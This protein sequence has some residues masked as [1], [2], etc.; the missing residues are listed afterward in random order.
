MEWLNVGSAARAYWQVLGASLPEEYRFAKRS[1][2]P[3][4]DDFN[5]ALN[6]LYGMLYSVVEGALFAAGLDPHL[7]ILHTD[8]YNKPVLVFDLIEAF[9]PWVDRLLVEECL[10]SNLEAQFF[11]KN[12]FGL[13]LN[14]KGKAYIIPLFNDYLRTQRRYFQRDSTVK[15]H[16]Y[17]LAARLANRIRTF[18][19]EVDIA[20]EIDPDLDIPNEGDAS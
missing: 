9:R 20:E 15:N 3:A 1:R 14:K 17:G 5:A 11:S 19:S 7:G 18:E 4:E 12:Q 2:R 6:Y 13:F 10:I 8:E 16:I